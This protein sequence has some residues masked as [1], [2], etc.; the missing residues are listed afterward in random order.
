MRSAAL[1]GV[2]WSDWLC[3]D[4]MSDLKE[5]IKK[6]LEF[7]FSE[8]DEVI[9]FFSMTILR[10]KVGKPIATVTWICDEATGEQGEAMSKKLFELAD[11]VKPIFFT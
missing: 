2:R 3:G 7:V 10:N 5:R 4:F 1:L 6:E 11:I 8:E 9:G